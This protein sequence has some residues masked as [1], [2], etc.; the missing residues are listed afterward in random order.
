METKTFT[1][2]GFLKECYED[3]TSTETIELIDGDNR[4][5]FCC[6]GVSAWIKII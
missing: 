3:R 2:C 6:R 1:F 5:R 4:E